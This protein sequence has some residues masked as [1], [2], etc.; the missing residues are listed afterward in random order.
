MQRLRN[1]F[2]WLGRRNNEADV[3]YVYVANARV[4]RREVPPAPK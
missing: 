1:H 2:G 3:V 4:R